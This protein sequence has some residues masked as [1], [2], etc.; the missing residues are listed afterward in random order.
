MFGREPNL[1]I[2]IELGL[3]KQNERSGSLTKYVD[4]LKERLRK[5]YELASEAIQ[6]S[7][8]DKKTTMIS[9]PEELF[10]KSEIAS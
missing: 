3:D 6:K 7:Q 5:S 2:D 1:P 4:N 10:W 8:K 9:S